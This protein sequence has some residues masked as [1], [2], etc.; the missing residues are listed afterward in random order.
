[1]PATKVEGRRCN[2][3]NRRLVSANTSCITKLASPRCG[4]S[5]VEVFRA[6]GAKDM[7]K[8]VLKIDRKQRR[9]RMAFFFSALGSRVDTDANSASI[10]VRPVAWR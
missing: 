10:K 7:G 6:A 2:C 3:R 4:E 5:A 9:Q 8:G 1:M